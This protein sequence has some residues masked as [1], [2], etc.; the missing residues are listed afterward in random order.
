MNDLTTITTITSME[1][2]ELVEK[3]HYNVVRDIKVQTKNLLP[4]DL[5]ALWKSTTYIDNSGKENP[6]FI[7]TKKG[8]LLIGSG[9]N[10]N[11]RLKIIN[12]WEE[13][14]NKNKI[15]QNFAEALRLAADQQEQIQKLEPRANYAVKLMTSPGLLEFSEV[16]KLLDIPNLGRNKLLKLLRDKNIFFKNRNEPKQI[17]INKG[18]FTLKENIINDRAIVQPYC[19]QKGLAYLHKVLDLI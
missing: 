7:L 18:Y 13:L 14:E 11:L 8:S 16:A 3:K 17:Y 6:C 2:A 19:T 9:Y 4:S 15:P 5:I 10:V 1:F 12:R